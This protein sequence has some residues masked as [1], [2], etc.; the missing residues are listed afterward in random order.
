MFSPLDTG[1]APSA[2]AHRVAAARLARARYACRYAAD[3]AVGPVLSAWQRLRSCGQAR[4]ETPHSKSSN[5]PRF[6]LIMLMVTEA[7]QTATW[8]GDCGGAGQRGIPAALASG[9]TACAIGR[10]PS[11]SASMCIALWFVRTTQSYAGYL[12]LIWPWQRDCSLYKSQIS[13]PK[14]QIAEASCLLPLASCLRRASCTCFGARV[15]LSRGAW[16]GALAPLR[17]WRQHCPRMW[18]GISGVAIAVACCSARTP[19]P[20]A[21]AIRSR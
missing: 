9:N 1:Q 6:I 17:R 14:Y 15:F 20:A 5:G 21:S 2:D 11:S 4:S 3:L 13:K 8:L 12:G 16:L 10:R 19:S 18:L 7:G